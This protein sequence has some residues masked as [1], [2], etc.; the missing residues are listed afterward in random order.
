MCAPKVLRSCYK[1]F[2]FQAHYLFLYR[3]CRGL[4]VVFPIGKG[5]WF[6]YKL[7]MGTLTSPG[8][9]LRHCKQVTMWKD[10]WENRFSWLLAQS[11]RLEMV[12]GKKTEEEL[13]PA[14]HSL[15]TETTE[16]PSPFF[17]ASVC[18]PFFCFS[19]ERQFCL[20]RKVP[21][22]HHGG[23]ELAGPEIQA[24]SFLLYPLV[25]SQ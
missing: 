5:C 4:V 17:S 7:V 20:G 2:I 14:F 3:Y 21:F 11:S 6:E 8:D 12:N 23:A 10:K 22:L 25:Y 24:L 13:S 16:P 15:P 18:A 19:W 9:L 1:C